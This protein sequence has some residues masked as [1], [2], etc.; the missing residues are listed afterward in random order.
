MLHLYLDNFR[1]FTDTLIPFAPVSFLVG[2]NSTG[3]SSVLALI[4]LISSP[5]FWFSQNFNVEEYEF[6]G[7]RDIL[8][9]GSPAD[10]E[11][12]F[13]IFAGPLEGREKQAAKTYSFLA[14]YREKDAL[15][16]LTFFGRIRDGNL[17][18]VR[19]D[20]KSWKYRTDKVLRNIPVVEPRTVFQILQE[21][22]GNTKNAYKDVPKAISSQS[23][24]FP[25]LAMLEALDTNEKPD[26]LE[27]LF[28]LPQL[29]WLAPIRTKPKRTYDGYGAYYSPEGEHTP[30]LLRKKLTSGKKAETFRSALE[31]FGKASG[32]FSGVEIHKLSQD[33]TAPFEL[34]VHLRPACPLRI[35]SVGYGVSQVL[36]VVVEMLARSKHSWFSIQQPEVHLHPRAQA[37]LGDLIFQMAEHENKRFL[38][39][40]H[41]DFTID[42]F[43]LNFKRS[44][45]H[46]TEAQVLFFER[47]ERG[48]FVHTLRIRPDGEYPQDQPGSF[49]EFFLKEQIELLEL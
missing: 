27:F 17:L 16:M 37:A 39:E 19:R 8:S 25:I 15:P 5:D 4:N 23:G 9:S 2:E 21:E 14:S 7:F 36:P 30:Y 18:A 42:R 47:G 29:A 31:T 13:G 34:V 49:R 44:S 12:T 22:R 46:K 41:S 43:R 33:A 6:G 10:A 40:T 32:L 3:K 24:V 26:H 35:N 11:F 20:R 1:G 48:N 38:I 28:P 45:E